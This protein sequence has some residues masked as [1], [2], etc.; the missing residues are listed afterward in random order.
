MATSA[1]INRQ[2]TQHLTSCI[3]GQ[4]FGSHASEG[5]LAYKHAKTGANTIIR[6][7]LFG[8]GD[9]PEKLNRKAGTLQFMFFAYAALVDGQFI[10]GRRALGHDICIPLKTILV[11]ASGIRQEH[12]L[13]RLPGGEELLN[14]IAKSTINIDMMEAALSEH[15]RELQ[16]NVCEQAEEQELNVEHIVLSYPHYL[17][18]NGGQKETDKY[19]SYYTRLMQRIWGEHIQFNSV[20]EGFALSLYLSEPFDEGTSFLSRKALSKLYSKVDRTQGLNLVIID[21]GGSSMNIQTISLYYGTDGQFIC[22]QANESPDWCEGTQGGSDLMNTQIKDVAREM[23]RSHVT[24]GELAVFLNDFEQQKYDIDCALDST[25]ETIKLNGIEKQFIRLQ[26]ESSER[27]VNIPARTIKKI[28]KDVFNNGRRV[29][30]DEIKVQLDIGRPFVALFCGGSFA[31]PGL[32]NQASRDMEK[33]KELAEQRGT[34]F[35]YAFLEKFDRQSASAV[36]SGCAIS[37]LRMPP[38]R[39]VINGSAV[40]I[41]KQT[42]TSPSSDEWRGL[43]AAD[44]LFHKGDGGRVRELKYSN[45]AQWPAR[46]RFA[47]LC[48]PNYHE[49]GLGND[50]APDAIPIGSG[51]EVWNRSMTTYDLGF[52][53]NAKDLP[54]DKIRFTVKGYKNGGIVR[55]R[56]DKKWILTLRTHP[57]CKLL[58]VSS[59]DVE[60][61]PSWCSGCGQEIT[62]VAYISSESPGQDGGYGYIRNSKL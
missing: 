51:A 22:S 31:G 17:L 62:M 41:Q 40:L 36:A 32:R 27:R 5:T 56:L 7:A 26:G 45:S 59:E 19:M 54:R 30:K 34:S 52:E 4:D 6:V 24:P 8:D 53:I 48:D 18:R 11:F 23:L 47:L 43:K 55:D 42:R 29:W 15:F 61:C 46:R 58:N 16:R 10:V 57:E 33:Y 60:L 38:A 20:K 2:E 39:S 35:E 13:V 9:H 49:R 28:F 37:M 14:G 3:Y 12:I 21:M 1:S 25:S 44:V 50:T